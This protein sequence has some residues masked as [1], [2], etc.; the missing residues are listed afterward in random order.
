MLRLT[1]AWS[2]STECVFLCLVI[3]IVLALETL[4][5]W[6]GSQ[7][8][9]RSRSTLWVT[10]GVC[11]FISKGIHEVVGDLIY[12]RPSLAEAWWFWVF[13]EFRGLY[14]RQSGFENGIVTICDDQ[15]TGASENE[16][17]AFW[18]LKIESETQQQPA[19]QDLDDLQDVL[20]ALRE[21]KKRHMSLS[22]S[23]LDPSFVRPASN[24]VERFFSKAGRILQT[25]RCS[26]YRLEQQLFFAWKF[27]I[28][29]W[30]RSSGASESNSEWSYCY[31]YCV[32]NIHIIV[33]LRKT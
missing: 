26:P 9:Q 33:L 24:M 25:R 30:R 8:A 23:Y 29:G 1:L 15:L 2:F 27:H 7:D 6:R 13:F 11:G 12:V 17:R 31:N 14:C 21:R 28:L 10:F 16:L 20:A 5:E 18:K 22:K 4:P 32:F 3:R 19:P